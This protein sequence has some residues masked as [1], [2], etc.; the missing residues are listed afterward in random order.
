MNPLRLAQTALVGCGLALLVLPAAAD[1]VQLYNGD[2]LTG[3]VVS[4]DDKHL[5]LES[6]ILGQVNIP[7]AKV[8]SITLGNQ[9]PVTALSPAP[10]KTAAKEPRPSEMSPEDVLKQLKST[11]VTAKDTRDLQKMLPLLSTPEASKYFND[12]VK[13]LMGGKRTIGDLRKDAMRARDELKKATKGLGPDVE[14]GVAPYLQILD[15]FL[16]ETEPA[17]KMEKAPPQKK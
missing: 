2:M 10:A 16:R 15:S 13:D 7:R 9:K 12:T 6:E 14:A 17:K 3:R 5:R 8:S 4:L 11:G 1:S